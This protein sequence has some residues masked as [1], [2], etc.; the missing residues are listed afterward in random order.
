MLR[1]LVHARFDLFR[2]YLTVCP[3]AAGFYDARPFVANGIA[4]GRRKKAALLQ[5]EKRVVRIGVEG[6]QGFPRVRSARYA[7]ERVDRQA[8]TGG[9]AASSA[10]ETDFQAFECPEA[11][12]RPSTAAASRSGDNQKATNA[13]GFR[14]FENPPPFDLQDVPI[15]MDNLGWKVSARL[16]RIWFAGAAHI[17]NNDPA[18][19]Q[20]LN[21]MQPSE[22]LKFSAKN[23]LNTKNRAPSIA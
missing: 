15:A 16:A 21:D 4:H 2:Q 1:A 22:M 20:P 11:S 5:T 23:T 10:T 17:Y 12:C 14:G 8:C 19:A 18:S 13:G 6:I 9:K 3:F 7:K